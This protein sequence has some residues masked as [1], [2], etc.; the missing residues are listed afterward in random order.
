M[1]NGIAQAV[2]VRDG[3]IIAVGADADIAPHIGESTEVVDLAGR[4]LLPGFQDSHVHPVLAGLTMIR[5]DL[6]EARDADH[7][8]ELIAAYAGAN[9]D[10]EWIGGGGWS[11]DWFPGGTPARGLLDAIVPDRPIH[12]INQDGHGAWVN[13]KALEVCGLDADT[14]DPQD[15]R[16][17]REPDGFPQGTLHEG[18]SNLVSGR[19]PEPSSAD[20][21]RGLH[22]GQERLH[23]VGVT[24]WQDAMVSPEVQQAYESAADAG[25]LTGRVVGALW[26]DRERG[27]EQI[28]ELVAR[29]RATGRFRTTSVK[30][31]QDGVAENFTAAMTS[32]YLDGCGCG[33]GNHGLSFV[34]P[35]ALRDH[36]TGL[37]AEGFQVHIH[38]VGDRAAR[39]ALDAFAQAREV[40]GANDNRHHIAHLQVVHPD[41]VPR[42][43]ALG[44]TANMQPLW[45]AYEPAMNE[46]TI[47][48]LGAERAEWQYPFGDL[49]R[50]G[51]SL[52]AGSDWPVSSADPLLGLHVAVNRSI[53]DEPYDVF[54]PAQCLDVT[55][56]FTAY[57]LG[58]ARVN[59]LE[60]DTGTI[61]VGKYADLITLDRDPFTDPDRIL[62]TKVLATYVEGAEVYRA[63]SP[64]HV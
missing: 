33:T 9:P 3:R 56:A 39:E 40:N 15:G 8:L 41:D 55:T 48:F 19:M 60:S 50:T 47:P 18:A 27:A 31:M 46:L 7:A 25:T 17:E 14:P 42:F 34:D 16:I 58:T 43:A 61:E 51:A 21:L 63:S 53:P 35:V 6:H 45:A 5:C 20:L 4:A 64:A 44:I 59:H 1:T 24:A 26:W 12:L 30:I 54:F 23:S 28:P 29:R 37:D 57:T 2:A 11:M 36:V 62:E 22:A 38:A 32:S 13:T 10:E 52:A 49:H